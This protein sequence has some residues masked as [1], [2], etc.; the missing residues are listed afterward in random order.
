E[1]KAYTADGQDVLSMNADAKLA[2]IHM[3]S[4]KQEAKDILNQMEID[5]TLSKETKDELNKTVLNGRWFSSVIDEK[6][7]E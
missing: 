6:Y 2:K 5:G 1:W 4:D 7:A 3:T